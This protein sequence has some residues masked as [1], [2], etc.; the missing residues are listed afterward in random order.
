M[1]QDNARHHCEQVLGG[2]TVPRPFDLEGLRLELEHHRGRDLLL[3]GVH[4]HGVSPSG[5]WISS[6]TADYIFFEDSHSEYD[7]ARRVCHDLG[8]MLLDHTD[9]SPFS[10]SYL[11]S[12]LPELA[13]TAI[14]RVLGRT[15]YS[16]QQEDDA[17]TMATIILERA[18]IPH[19]PQPRLG[20]HDV[21][22]ELC[23]LAAAL[24]RTD[25]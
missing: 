10:A 18:G 24:Q 22:V 9:V 21:T 8:H 7:I 20:F 13:P 11:A 3:I 17:D 16:Q 6:F 14:E 2:V 19:I 12:T 25:R 23:R 1:R 5:L 4:P 15:A